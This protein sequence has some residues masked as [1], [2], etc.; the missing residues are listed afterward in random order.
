MA[1][2]M[3]YFISVFL[4]TFL[5]CQPVEFNWDKTIEGTCTN[6]GLAYLLAGI[7][8]LLID[9]LIVVLPMPVLWKLKL[10]LAQKFGISAM[11]GLGAL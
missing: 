6:Q 8:N 4:E 7:T 11:F 5:L 1:L 3:G 2:S 10:P 9:V